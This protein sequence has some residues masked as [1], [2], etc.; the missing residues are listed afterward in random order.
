MN[1]GEQDFIFI[2]PSS[3]DIR[4][5][6]AFYNQGHFYKHLRLTG[7][8][9]LDKGI[10]GTYEMK[11]PIKPD[12]ARVFRYHKVEYVDRRDNKTLQSPPAI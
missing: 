4:P 5:D 1:E 3:P 10:P 7:R 11:T 2:E 8:F 9:Y 12:H 6:S